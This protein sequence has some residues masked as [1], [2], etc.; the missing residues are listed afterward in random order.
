MACL[1]MTGLLRLPGLAFGQPLSFEVFTLENGLKIFY[2]QDPPIK[3]T[4]LVF[5]FAGGQALEKENQPGLAYM[6]TR[7]MAEVT[8]EVKLSNLLADGVNLT[9]G[10][11]PD[12]SFI[13]FDGNSQ[14]LDRTL[15]I[16]ASSLKDPLFSGLRIDHVRKT[17][18]M[19]SGRESC[20]L[21]D[22]ALICLHQQLFPEAPYRFSIYGTE[23]SLKSLRKKDL[24]NFYELI[25]HPEN[26]NLIVISDLEAETIVSLISKHFSWIK[27]AANGSPFP[28]FPV[29]EKNL[30]P[31]RSADCN[32]YQGP[33]GAAVLLAYVLPGELSEIY[34]AAYL[35]EKMIGEGPA[36]LIWSLRQESGLAYNLNSRLELIGRSAI[37]IC[38][39]ETDSK[40]ARPALT[41]L[42]ETFTRLG[43]QGLS[44]QEVETSKL[45]ARNNYIRES[46][47][48]DHRLAF[49]SLSLAC[50]LPLEFYNYFLDNLEAV[51]SD[52]INRLV[53][54]AFKAERAYE[55]AVIRD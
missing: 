10:S 24:N 40:S 43:Q 22:S 14:H 41:I 27:K 25:L 21:V 9:A 5:H 3:F 26:L 37:L 20:R 11:R 34:P 31:A 1:V 18:K 47:S 15:S 50:N 32:H 12:F 7:L 28:V 19:E 52:N 44:E 13:Q 35:L 39:M 36:S 4:T 2:Q 51:S 6:T 42:K 46:F 16:I 33:A 30:N 38:Y 48:R 49:L 29:S 8:D 53:R 17:L 55:V 45:L 54:G 23:P